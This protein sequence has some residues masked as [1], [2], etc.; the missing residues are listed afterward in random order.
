MG[1][2][3]LTRSDLPQA[4]EQVLARDMAKKAV[5]FAPVPIILSAFV[6]GFDGAVSSAVGVVVVVVN[7]LLAAALM[8]W[9]ARISIGLLMGAALGGYILRLGLILVTVLLIKDFSWVEIIPLGLTLVVTHLGLLVW[10]MR[11]VS[12]S[13]AFPDLRPTSP[14]ATHAPTPVAARNENKE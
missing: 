14:S 6:W 3:F 13:L 2:A 7:F 4:P 11:Y 8:A 5:P 10:E 9:S 12:A 1:E